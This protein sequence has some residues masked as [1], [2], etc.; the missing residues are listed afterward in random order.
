MIPSV[1]NTSPKAQRNILLNQITNRSLLVSF[2]L[3][4]SQNSKKNKPG[5]QQKLQIR[6]CNREYHPLLLGI[7]RNDVASQNWTTAFLSSLTFLHKTQPQK[8]S[9]LSKIRNKIFCV[10][11][12]LFSPNFF[13]LFVN[14][15]GR[16]C[17]HIQFF[18][19]GCLL[20]PIYF[21]QHKLGTIGFNQ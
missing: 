6:N 1:M 2:A 21:Y 5:L 19:N 3:I 16:E 11:Y 13:A 18:A 17:I 15:K 4:M 8:Q 12:S 20:P 9:E 14:N 7:K 10:H